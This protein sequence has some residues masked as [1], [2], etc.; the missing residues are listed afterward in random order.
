VSSLCEDPA[1]SGWVCGP[2]TEIEIGNEFPRNAQVEMVFDIGEAVAG[3][4]LEFV[5]GG[6]TGVVTVPNGRFAMS[7]NFQNQD[8]A[9]ALII[10]AGSLEIKSGGVEQRLI[11]LISINV[12]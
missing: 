6:S 12:R 4:D 3:T 8:Q 2:E 1:N 11:R 10:R 9:Q 7:L 5:L